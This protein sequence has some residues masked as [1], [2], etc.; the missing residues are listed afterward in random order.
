MQA[1]IGEPRGMDYTLPAGLTSTTQ[2]EIL[3]ASSSV[4]VACRRRRNS[5]AVDGRGSEGAGW[6]SLSPNQNTR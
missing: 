5:S 2:I 6:Q 4:N 3:R 1:Y